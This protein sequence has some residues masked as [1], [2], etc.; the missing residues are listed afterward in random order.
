MRRSRAIVFAAGICLTSAFAGNQLPTSNDADSIEIEPPLLIQN[1]NRDKLPDTDGAAVASTVP[2]IAKLEK[3]IERA[4]RAS[5]G[6]ERLFRIGVLARQDVEQR[7]LRI[8]RLQSDRE[9]AR[10]AEA[11]TSAID[12]ERR[13][14]AGEISKEELVEAEKAV[15]GATQ[16][17]QN[18]AASR[19][20]AELAAAEVNLQR[21][22]K[23][24]TLGSG[25]KSDVNKAAQKLAELS[26]PNGN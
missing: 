9:N 10:L 26:I 4:K 7:A 24:L 3:S 21:Q 12:R 13:F 11:R 19:R 20:Q 18:A 16:A 25:H 17:A 8:V 22:K 2:D 1:L 6:A 23:L 14:A 15:E 5:A